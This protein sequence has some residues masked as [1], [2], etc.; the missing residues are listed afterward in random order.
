MDS[1]KRHEVWEN[2]YEEPANPLDTTWGFKIKENSQGEPL[3][4]KSQFCVQGFNQIYGTDFEETYTPTREP[5]TLCILLLYAASKS[6]DIL[7]FDVQGAFLHAPLKSACDPCMY[8]C[9][10]GASFIFFHVDDLVLVGPGNNFK[11]KF[12]HRFSNSAC[13]SP[14]TLLGMKSED[15]RQNLSFST[16]TNQPQCGAYIGKGVTAGLSSCCC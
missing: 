6:L 8:A 4:F 7:Q 1:I 16:K 12:A 9:E 3:K 2:H 10:D 13:H 11:N 15:W 14:N 5:A